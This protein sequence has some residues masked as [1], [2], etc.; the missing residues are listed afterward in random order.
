MKK[1]TNAGKIRKFFNDLPKGAEFTSRE[2]CVGTGLSSNSVTGIFTEMHK[3]G[4]I[5]IVRQSVSESGASALRPR[6]FYQV[7]D[8]SRW[9]SRDYIEVP[10]NKNK[11]KKVAHKSRH[12]ITTA[13]PPITK[14]RPVGPKFTDLVQQF[15]SLASDQ[16]LITTAQYLLK[17]YEN[18]QKQG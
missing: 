3:K 4:I 8:L 13:S 5:K 12:T 10:D 1:I 15:E 2:V 11:I 16:D 14:Y 17:T 18:R 6:N 9:K 7:A